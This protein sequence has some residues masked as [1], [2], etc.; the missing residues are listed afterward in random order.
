MAIAATTGTNGINGATR[1]SFGLSFNVAKVAIATETI[2]RPKP[3]PSVFS[4][5][6]LNWA[7]N[8]PAMRSTVASRLTKAET[9]DRFPPRSEAGNLEVGGSVIVA[10]ASLEP[11]ALPRIRI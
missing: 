11:L 6:T 5:W 1:A 9:P 10:H 7:S 3:S 2:E 4:R 8:L